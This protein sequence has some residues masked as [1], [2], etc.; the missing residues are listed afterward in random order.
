[1]QRGYKKRRR[2]KIN[3]I[4]KAFALTLTFIKDNVLNFK[5]FHVNKILGFVKVFY[6]YLAFV[7]IFGFSL[8]IAEEAMQVCMWGNFA[9]QDAGRYDLI[10][11]N[12]ET[13]GKTNEI[14]QKINDSCMWINPFQYWGYGA[15][16]DG[17]DAYV[18]SMQGLILAKEPSL[19]TSERISMN[20]KWDSYK[21]GK[22]GF[23]VAVNGKVK[24]IL[25]FEPKKK[26]LAISGVVSID[27]DVE[28]GV[29]ITAQ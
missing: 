27:P 28:K 16:S 13:I 14:F 15:W 8:F 9:A 7:G 25:N 20:F 23:Y 18:A 21:R 11:N 22:N 10:K 26:T 5:I 3:I 29:I 24:V 6:F 19:Y 1:M 17:T 2:K 12:I 4:K